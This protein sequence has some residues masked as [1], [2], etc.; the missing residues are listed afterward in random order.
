M[1]DTFQQLYREETSSFALRST[2]DPA[3]PRSCSTLCVKGYEKVSLMIKEKF[4]L[5]LTEREWRRVSF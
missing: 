2:E 5:Y 3:S 1:I 4:L